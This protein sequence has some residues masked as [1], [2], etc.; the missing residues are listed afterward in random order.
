MKKVIYI[1][2][3]LFFIISLYYLVDFKLVFKLIAKANIFLIILA[4]VIGIVNSYLVALRFKTVF[5]FVRD[6]KVSYFWALSY[7][8]SF[9]STVFPFSLGGFSMAYFLSKKAKI[10]YKK[11]LM[12]IIV[13][14]AIGVSPIIFLAPIAYWYFLNNP[15][16]LLVSIFFIFFVFLTTK[17]PPLIKSFLI[18][19][20]IFIISN[21]QF[22]LFLRAYNLT[23]NFFDFILANSLLGILSFIPGAPGK[24]GQY[25]TFGVLTLPHLLNLNVDAVFTAMLSMRLVS[26]LMTFIF[27]YLSLYLLKVNLNDKK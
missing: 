18:S 7:I 26:T 20:F 12:M 16:F 23:P 27:G 6:I 4:T 1:A 9:V 2:L 10:N 17:N 14:F 5:T 13:D 24:V 19:L 8:G 11:S 3:T 15:I 25:E 21:L 22:Y